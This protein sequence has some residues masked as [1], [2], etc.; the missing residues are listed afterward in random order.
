MFWPRAAAALLSLA[1]LGGGCSEVKAPRGSLLLDP[2]QPLP[3][4]FS[5]VGLYPRAPDLLAVP[6]Q[7]VAYEPQW[8]LWSNQSD[9]QRFIVLPE[10]A[11]LGVTGEVWDYPPGTLLFKTFTYPDADAEG[12]QRPVETRL[13]RL[14]ADGFW[15]FASYV[16]DERGRKATLGDMEQA[17]AVPATNADGDQ[18]EHMVPARLECRSCHESHP[19]P[20]L[21]FNGL[22]LGEQLNTLSALFDAAPASAAPIAHPDPDTE[23]VLGLLQGNCV[24]CHNG[25]DGPSSSFDMR[26]PVALENLINV[27]TTSSASAAGLRVAAGRPLDSVLFL[28]FSGEHDDPEIEPMPPLGVD[29]RDARSVELLRDWITDLEDP[30]ESD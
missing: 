6:A 3:E 17:Q 2:L 4:R 8:P 7:A 5:K 24:H 11:Q 12:G 19:D 27:E 15:E 22:Q 20:V 25:W 29:V 26:H 18:F 30:D 23:Q 9:K 14:D 1:L 10:E 21:G 28:G 13:M 16:W